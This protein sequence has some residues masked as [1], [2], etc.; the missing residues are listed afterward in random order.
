MIVMILQAD[1]KKYLRRNV[2]KRGGIDFIHV[3]QL[4]IP[5]PCC[6]WSLVYGAWGCEDVFERLI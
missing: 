4:C 5:L 6:F 3:M 2:G 1:W